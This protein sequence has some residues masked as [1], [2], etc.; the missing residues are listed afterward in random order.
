MSNNDVVE[1]AQVALT[2]LA[3]A[4]G[5]C[6]FSFQHVDGRDLFTVHA[7]AHGASMQGQGADLAEAL[8]N[9]RTVTKPV[10]VAA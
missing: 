1:A 2:M 9:L 4:T 5:S 3:G 6:S 8:A 7:H 10:L